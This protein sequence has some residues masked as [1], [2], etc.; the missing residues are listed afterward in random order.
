MDH[1]AES[2]REEKNNLFYEKLWCFYINIFWRKH[3]LVLNLD[4]NI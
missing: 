1:W 3:V 2:Y 4:F